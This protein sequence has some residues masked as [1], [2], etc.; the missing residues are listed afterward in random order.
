MF[1]NTTENIKGYQK[2]M[3]NSFTKALL[4]TSSGDHII[5]ACY[6]G[7]KKIIAYDINR[8]TKYFAS[9]KIAALSLLN[10]DEFI[11]FFYDKPLNYKYLSSLLPLLPT[12]SADFWKA[13][14]KDYPHEEI[15]I[16]LFNTIN[17]YPQNKTITNIEAYKYLSQKTLNYLDKNKYQNIQDKIRKTSI[18]YIDCDIKDVRNYLQTQTFDYINLTN[19]YDFKNNIDIVKEAKD[20]LQI[21]KFL[22]SRL[23]DKGQLLI[24]YIYN[25][26]LTEIYDLA[27]EYMPKNPFLKYLHNN[28][29][30]Y[31]KSY[32]YKYMQSI[33]NSYEKDKISSYCNYLLLKKL[34]NYPLEY[35]EIEPTRINLKD[36]KNTKDM[37]IVYTKNR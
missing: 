28:L 27:L 29:S 35:Y 12:A 18:T 22:I 33:E 5:E 24:H 2:N 1:Y 7:S 32:F 3:T 31:N 14:I 23:E 34:N 30:T 26:S 19:I 20:Y 21:I 16:K 6:M 4:P 36:N 9:L 37:A 8:F 17:I 25:K 10:Y 15:L 13:I 11:N